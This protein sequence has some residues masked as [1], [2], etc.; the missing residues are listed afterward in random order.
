MRALKALYFMKIL[1]Y[2][3]KTGS[4]AW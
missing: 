2:K 4:T 1:K 3:L